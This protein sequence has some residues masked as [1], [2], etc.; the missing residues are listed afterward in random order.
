MYRK[1]WFTVISLVLVA[2]FVVSCA[3]PAAP[4]A[5]PATQPAGGVVTEPAAATATEPV[6]GEATEPVTEA[7][8]EAAAAS[9]PPPGQ[10]ITWAFGQP[11][12]LQMW[13][14]DYLARNNIEG[15]TSEMVTTT[16][17]EEVRERT[18]LAF[19]G[20]AFDDMAD[21]ISTFPVSMQAMADA[22]MLVDLTEYLEPLEDRFVPGTFD[23][24]YYKG[25]LYC[26]PRSLR[27]QLLFYNQAL[28]EQYDI[29]PERMQTFEGY[30]EVG[31]ELKEASNGEV[32]L[33]YEDPATRTWRYWGRRG[34]MPQANARIWDDEG[35]VVIDTDPGA[36]KAFEY[37]ASLHNEGLL[38]N[39][40]ILE[41]PLYEATRQG[42]V[43]TFYIG[44]FFDEF[45]KANLQDMAGNWRVMEAPVFEGME[46]FG[47][48]PVVDIQCLTNKP[49]AP[50]V[51]LYKDIWYDYNFNSE[52]RQAYT[53]RV[54]EENG[55]VQNPIS[56]EMLAEPFWQEP[57]PFYGGQ[58]FRQMEGQGLQNVSPN[59]RVT[60]ADAEADAIISAELEKFVA[61]AQT[62]DEAIANMGT[63]LRDRIGQAPPN[64]EP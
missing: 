19:T 9:P 2:A 15:V 53:L 1:P 6:A 26:L 11:R 4:T 24:I 41:P 57:D 43:A 31:R 34:L 52:A 14:E 23:Q 59:M 13:I 56:L 55:P 45:L 40:V 3:T 39:S 28:F 38:Y 54:I 12:F 29:D 8:T 21:V 5:V 37:L 62:M 27:P 44:A 22:G 64:P 36:R 20:N 51:D 16:G 18:M 58:S 25:R 30:L 49:D 61:N 7:P 33:S 63:I 48:A 47:G 32:F 60:T 46:E 42:Q 10:M 35:N 17:E 50:Y